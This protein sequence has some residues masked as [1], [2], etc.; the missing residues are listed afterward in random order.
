MGKCV[1]NGTA[2]QRLSCAVS[3]SIATGTG[4]G[5][6]AT[7]S[8]SGSDLGG[9]ITITAGTTP[10]ANATVVT[11]TFNTAF[12]TA[13]KTVLIT[14]ADN[15]ASA[16]L[17]SSAG[18]RAWFVEPSNISTTVFTVNSGSAVNAA[19]NGTEYKIHY[20]VTQ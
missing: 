16:V 9:V 19:V 10:A 2:W 15:D 18:S 4:A 6:G 13:P 3:P 5:T 7:A 1:Y 17:F 20:T 11:V 12:K 14:A 8:I